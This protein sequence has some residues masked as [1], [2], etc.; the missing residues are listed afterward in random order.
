M[1]RYETYLGL[2]GASE[3]GVLALAGWSGVGLVLILAFGLWVPLGLGPVRAWAVRDGGGEGAAAPMDWAR[4]LPVGLASG[5]ALAV[6]AWTFSLFL[7]GDFL[8]GNA[9]LCLAGLSS[10]GLAWAGRARLPGVLGQAGVFVCVSLFALGLGLWHH[11]ATDMSVDQG[12]AR[13]VF[14]D[15]QRDVGAHITMAGLVRDGGL[16]MQN[17]W[18]SE[19]HE[20]WIL[21]HTGHLAL[22]SGLSELLEISLYRAS[23]VLWINAMLLTVW[24]ALGLLAGARIPAAFRFILVGATLVWGAA[25]FPDFHRIYDPMREASAGGFELDAPGYWVAARAFWNLPQALSIALTFGALLL[26]QAFAAVRQAR[27]GFPWLLVVGTCLA[28]AGGWTKPSIIVFYGPALLLWLALNRAGTREYLSV[29]IPL[30]IG[31][32]VYSI[33]AVF[34][35]L[36][37]GSNWSSLP[38]L[39][40]WSRVGGFI[41]AAGA[42]LAI[43]ALYP[44]VNMAKSWSQPAEYRVLDL[45][46]LAAGGSVLFSLLFSEDAFVGDRV[47]QPNIWWGMS[48]CFV[49]GVPLLGRKGFGMLGDSG[50]RSLAAGVGLALGLLHVFNGF[51]LAIVYP[52]LNLRGHLASDA[53]VLAGAREQTLPG[54]RFALDPTL[55]EYDLLGYLA[56]PTL[57]KARTASAAQSQDFDAWQAFVQGPRASRM[58]FLGSLDAIVLRRDRRSVARALLS[59]NWVGASLDG[60]YDL[61]LAPAR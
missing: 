3:Q 23:S 34:F 11:A 16:P 59:R 4:V 17:L 36:P 42:G 18:G 57:M 8:L 58:P 29:G 37:E 27:P 54:M 45:A 14:S 6:G 49:L 22:I 31:G 51:C 28:V 1:E 61:W 50:W 47:F 20:Y 19:E 55:Q 35:D 46:L 2:L 53:E 26:L 7:F 13:L 40:Q 21:S 9:I 15:L 38:G 12:A 30:L 33:P 52:A 32:F 41:V 60:R 25:A 48:A 43:L 10:A 5:L 44:L 24:A 56:R 39:D